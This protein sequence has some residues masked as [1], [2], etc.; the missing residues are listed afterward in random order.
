MNANGWYKNLDRLINH[1]NQV[2]AALHGKPYK[3]LPDVAG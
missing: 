2:G 3:L 1:V